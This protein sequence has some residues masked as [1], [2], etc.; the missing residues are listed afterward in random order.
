M[1]RWS[2]NLNLPENEKRSIIKAYKRRSISIAS[3]VLE[4]VRKDVEELEE[5]EKRNSE[6]D[7]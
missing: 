6:R 7:A 4:H 5:S 3:R 2:I 1:S